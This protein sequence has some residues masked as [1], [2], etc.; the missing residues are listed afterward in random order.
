MQAMRNNFANNSERHVVYCVCVEAKQYE[1]NNRIHEKSANDLTVSEF[2]L[3]YNN[4][5]KKSML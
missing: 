1:N 2:A 5:N 3:R 4:A